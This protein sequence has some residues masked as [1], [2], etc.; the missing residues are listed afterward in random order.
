MKLPDTITL[1]FPHKADRDLGGN[2]R[3]YWR[4]KHN[5][6]KTDKEAAWAFT[7]EALT[8][9][10]TYATEF[11]THDNAFS[12]ED[13]LPINLLFRRYYGG[14]SKEWDQDNL[15]LSYKGLRDGIAL[16]LNINDRRIN[17]YVEQIRQAQP[18]RLEV[19]IAPAWA[20]VRRGAA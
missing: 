7:L 8:R 3:A 6:L 1:S 20:L 17:S 15:I 11:L 14:I 2:S 10:G 16:A 18:A 4:T 12:L 9:A 5:K 13:A 19:V